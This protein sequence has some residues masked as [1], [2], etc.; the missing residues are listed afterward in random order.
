MSLWGNVRVSNTTA[1]GNLWQRI[2][3]KVMEK[4]LGLIVHTTERVVVHTAWGGIMSLKNDIFGCMDHI[5]TAKTGKTWFIQ[6]T[7]DSGIGRKAAE[8]RLIPWNLRH[9]VVEI[10]R[11]VGGKKG[12]KLDRRF[13]ERKE[14]DRWY[15]QRYRLENDFKM[16]KG[17]T[18]S[19]SRDILNEV[20]SKKKFPKCKCG[21]PL[22]KLLEQKL[23]KCSACVRKGTGKTYETDPITRVVSGGPIG[24]S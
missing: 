19:I 20:N 24:H 23:D 12:K 15:F 10:W 8:I 14:L 7:I 1:K 13:K 2:A 11:G 16:V 4:K 6:T 18:I 21:K 3:Q 22:R 5:G 17:D 9:Q